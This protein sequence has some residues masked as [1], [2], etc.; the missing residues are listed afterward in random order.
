MCLLLVGA[1]SGG[2]AVGYFFVLVRETQRHL[3]RALLKYPFGG[4]GVGRGAGRGAG[5]GCPGARAIITSLGITSCIPA[6][7]IISKP[8]H[9]AT[10][11]R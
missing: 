10:K 4:R 3:R 2:V 6:F 8:Q 5:R 11:T 7:G 9:H 1:I